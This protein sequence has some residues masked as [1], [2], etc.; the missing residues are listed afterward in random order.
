MKERTLTMNLRVPLDRFDLEVDCVTKERVVGLFGPSGAGKTTWLEAVAG[1]RRQATG[2]LSLGDAVWLDSDRRIDLPPERRGI[3]YVPQDQRLFPHLNV[4]QNLLFAAGRAKGERRGEGA[5]FRDAVAVLE[6]EPL[7]ARRIDDLSGGERQRVALGRALC[8][9]PGLLLLDEP[10]ASLDIAMRHRILPFLKRVRDHFDGPMLIVSHQPFELQAL[11]DEVFALRAGKVVARGHP[12]GV[13]TDASVYG[14]TAG[15]GFENV[16]TAVLCSRSDTGSVLK[17]GDGTGAEL[18][19]FP[20]QAAVGDEVIVGIP[21]HDILVADHRVAGISARNIL[22][23]VV[24]GLREAEGRQLLFAR[25]GGEGTEP[26]V[27]ELTAE[28]VKDLRIAVG[29]EVY[30]LIKTSSIRLYDG[31]GG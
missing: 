10:L 19:A 6:L 3:G 29:R 14:A 17:I 24:T 5:N 23:A 20:V 2:K 13:F 21:A 25:V 28:S 26:L 31:S 15:E 4:K 8:S 30:L 12:T 7:L 11:C 22:P 27:V 16:L 18:V 1:L 9:G